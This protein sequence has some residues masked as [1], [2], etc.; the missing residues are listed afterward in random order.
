[1]L[2]AG[3]AGTAFPVFDGA[4]RYSRGEGYLLAL[5]ITAPSLQRVLDFHGG[6]D[7]LRAIVGP[8]KALRKGLDVD[9]RA[10]LL[11]GEMTDEEKKALAELQAKQK[12]EIGAPVT[13]DDLRFEA[14]LLEILG[15][16]RA[17][18][19]DARRLVVVYVKDS[20]TQTWQRGNSDELAAV[21]LLNLGIRSLLDKIKGV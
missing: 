11:F 4:A 14:D 17:G 7:T 8:C 20:R 10:G 9:G 2:D 19:V 3:F 5:E 6:E 15:E 18:K 16:I 21:G 12:V 13:S 1:M